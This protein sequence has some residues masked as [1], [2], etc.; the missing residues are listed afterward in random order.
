[1]EGLEPGEIIAADNFNRLQDGMKVA[2]TKPEEGPRD[3]PVKA[4]SGNGGKVAATKP[5]EGLRDDPIQASSG[6]GAKTAVSKP[7]QGPKKGH[8]GKKKNKAATEAGA[9][10]E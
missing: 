8:G 1:V 4:S 10:H 5:E 9:P 7:E 6:N 2:L 3:H